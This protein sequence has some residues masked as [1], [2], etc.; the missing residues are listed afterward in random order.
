MRLMTIILAG[1]L[2]G[3][4]DDEPQTVRQESNP[5]KMSMPNDQWHFFPCTMGEDQAFIYLNTGIAEEM[6]SAPANLVEI[7]LAYQA[8]NENGLPTHEEFQPVN[9]IEDRIEAFSEEERDWYVGRVTVGGHRI[10]F[11]YT[12][13]E[14][15]VWEGFIKKLGSQSGY[16]LLVS[17]SDDPEHKGYFNDLYPSADDWQIIKDLEVIEQLGEHGDDGSAKRKVDHWLFF[18]DKESA[19]GFV[20]WAESDRFTEETE[21]SHETDDGRYCVRL[22]HHGTLKIGDIGNHTVALRR[23]AEEFGGEYDGWETPVVKSSE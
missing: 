10:F 22:Y 11:V 9:E 2:M 7:R 13:R 6:G 5:E 20:A 14:E 12:S 21:Y 15:S 4:S 18:K 23:K 16:K 3:C 1:F 17:Y 8:P 19:K